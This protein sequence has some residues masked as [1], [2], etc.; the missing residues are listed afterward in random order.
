ML[1][2]IE[3]H[4]HDLVWVTMQGH[5]AMEHAERY[6][7]EIW[8][9]FDGCPRPTDLLVDGRQMQS[10][11]T[12][13]R[14]RTEQI[15]HHPHLGHIAFVVGSQHLFFAPLVQL[16]SGIG[17]FGDE[18]AALDYLQR[19]RGT[20]SIPS[21]GLPSMPARP[22]ETQRTPPPAQQGGLAGMLDSWSNSLRQITRNIEHD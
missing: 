15:V 4:A 19:T 14:Q 7:Q 9:T 21:V 2:K 18:H 12:V 10:A 6:F 20:P 1:Y 11:P 16:L 22:Q 13:A 3:R 17:M 8:R 5:M